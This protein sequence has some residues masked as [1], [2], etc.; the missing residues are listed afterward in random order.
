IVH[1]MASSIHLE[2]EL[3]QGSIFGFE[4]LT[5]VEQGE[6][7][8][9]G[10]FSQVKRCL[11]IDDNANNRLI[12]ERMLQVF[13]IASESCENGTL[14]L[15]R[16][17]KSKPFDVIICDYYMPGMDGL[18][19]VRLIR[20]KLESTSDKQPIILLHSSSD[21][22]RLFQKCEELGIRFR[23]VK[24]VKMGELAAY[25]YQLND[26][27]HRI[28][29][30]SQSSQIFVGQSSNYS[31]IL[32]AEDVLMN[33]ML[34][35]SLLKKLVPNAKVL[36]AVTGYEAV[37]KYQ[38]SQLDLVFMDVQMPGMD[39]LTATRKIRELER[40]SGKQVPIIALTAGAFKEDMEKC[41]AAG[42][43]DFLTKPIDMQKIEEILQKYLIQKDDE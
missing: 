12:L 27:P 3:G 14:A 36:E 1:K 16:L 6:K 2:S 42:M 26:S 38:E 18:E 11:V 35:K 37:D 22:A 30:P 28:K 15:N 40:K 34:L 9:L 10:E 43:N 23:L 21:D 31:S 32:I 5:Q 19:T 17:E 8:K 4:L 13:G 33:T 29:L 7:L 24:P 41:I 25:L 20:E 39:G